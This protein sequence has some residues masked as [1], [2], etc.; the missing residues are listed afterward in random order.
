MVPSTPWPAAS[1]WLIMKVPDHVCCPW[2]TSSAGWL[3]MCSCTQAC[4]WKCDQMLALTNALSL[5]LGCL[6]QRNAIDPPLSIQSTFRCADSF[7]L[8][9][10][11]TPSTELTYSPHLQF[12]WDLSECHL[13]PLSVF[14]IGLYGVWWI[15]TMWWWHM[16]FVRTVL[17]EILSTKCERRLTDLYLCVSTNFLLY[18]FTF[19]SDLHWEHIITLPFSLTIELCFVIAT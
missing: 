12:S 6:L 10:V 17:E 2:V 7:I 11:S 13:L 18:Y 4:K 8:Q 1:V 3:T 16:V 14:T 15:S 9:S 5:H 19:R